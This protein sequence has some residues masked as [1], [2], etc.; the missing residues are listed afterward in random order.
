VSCNN[1]TVSNRQLTGLTFTDWLIN[2]TGVTKEQFNQLNP[3]RLRKAIEKKIDKIFKLASK[4][5]N[6]SL[7]DE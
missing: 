5:K 1:A 7:Y 4:L 6:S 3:F 2:P